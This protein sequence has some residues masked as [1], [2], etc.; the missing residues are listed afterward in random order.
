MRRISQQL[1]CDRRSIPNARQANAR[2]RSAAV[3]HPHVVLVAPASSNAL[4]L[5]KTSAAVEQL[6]AKGDLHL[7]GGTLDP[8]REYEHVAVPPKR[9]AVDLA[10]VRR[11]VEFERDRIASRHVRGLVA[12]RRIAVLDADGAALDP[13]CCGAERA[14]LPVE[15][16]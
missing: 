16:P 1:L 11:Q 15:H 2:R 7:A 10:L 8:A 3:K 12:K 9:R 6:V 13:G 5:S 14:P 4:G